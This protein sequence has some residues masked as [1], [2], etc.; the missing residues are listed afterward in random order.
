MKKKKLP[1]LGKKLLA[2]Q[3]KENKHSLVGWAWRQGDEEKI[4][5]GDICFAGLSQLGGLDEF[6]FPISNGEGW[7]KTPAAVSDKEKEHVIDRKD[8]WN[9]IVLRSYLNY[10][11]N[12]S[13][14]SDCFITKRVQDAVKYGV[15]CNT[16]HTLS[17]YVTGCVAI[18]VAWEYTLH[19]HLW[20]KLYKDGVH[21]DIALIISHSFL[22]CKG[23]D[24]LFVNNS[25]T[26]NGHSLFGTASFKCYNTLLKQ[27][28][29]EATDKK[30]KGFAIFQTTCT[31]LEGK[32]WYDEDNAKDK[33]ATL[34][35]H[36]N[37]VIKSNGGFGNYNTE[38]YDYND[39]RSF[40]LKWTRDILLGEVHA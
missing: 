37:I 23:Q 5:A 17:Y 26:G 2:I 14:F 36:K 3:E 22:K 1:H 30:D 18:R 16:K 11:L 33:I 27:G 12:E 15:K 32:M 39:I 40:A 4:I 19:L 8:L 20:Y 13:I 38:V 9:N 35:P 34:I 31:L 6:V 25:C 10:I 29:Y 21:P 7:V 24:D 28:L